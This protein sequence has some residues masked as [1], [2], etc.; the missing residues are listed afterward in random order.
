VHPD[1]HKIGTR[2]C[3]VGGGISGLTTAY[4]LRSRGHNVTLFEASSEVGGNI[5]S[6]KRDGFL[7]EHGPNS[8]L[9]FPRVVELIDALELRSAVL[10]TS[11][12]AKKRFVLL[13]G[14]LQPLPTGVGSFV[15][16]DFFSGKAM[17]RLLKEPLV[18]TRSGTGESVA[19]FFERRLGP[20]VVEK[21]V[22]P[23]I[24]GIFAGDPE[25]L[26]IREAFPKLFEFEELHGSLLRGAVSSKREKVDKTF[27]RSFTFQNGLD[28]LTDRL[29]ELIGTGAETGVTVDRIDI[30]ENGYRISTDRASAEEF[31]AVV[32]STKADAAASMVQDINESLA[33]RLRDVYYPPLTVVRLGYRTSA[34]KFMTEG[35]GFLVPKSEGR[36]ILGSLWTSN[37]FPGRAPDGISL[38]TSFVGGARSPELFD[39]SDEETTELVHTELKE[40][41]E[42]VEPPSFTSLT[43]WKKAIPQY[44]IG[45]KETVEA[46]EKFVISN[47]GIFICSN[48]YRGISVG[49]CIK[50]AY[51]TAD[52]VASLI[53]LKQKR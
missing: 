38:F 47:P 37:V 40:I 20:E 51:R 28:T 12:S 23:F 7:L 33:G 32:I 29:K 44:N 43:R 16:G 8:L 21:A 18:S 19:A 35:F 25:K 39:L 36:G 31:D 2:I 42:I 5:R 24:S 11:P 10:P 3:V 34:V 49:D 6:E 13:G 14:K 17:L 27:P 52:E 22:D 53:Q 4:L 26:S 1:Q 30:T 45:Y 50:N 46:I 15:F 48:F 41:L 9:R